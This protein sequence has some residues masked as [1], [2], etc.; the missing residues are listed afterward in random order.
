MSPDDGN[1]RR[2]LT[3]RGDEMVDWPFKIRRKLGELES[4][5][6]DSAAKVQALAAKR[7]QLDND[8]ETVTNE[9]NR[10]P[11]EQR[12]Q[13]QH[14][15]DGIMNELKD[16]DREVERRRARHFNDSQVAIHCREWLNLL[17][18]SAE[19]DEFPMSE[20]VAEIGDLN[21]LRFEIDQIKRQ[22]TEVSAA[23]L[24]AGDLREKV[25]AYVRWRGSRHAPDI[26]VVGNDF[27]VSWM[28]VDVLGNPE[29]VAGI[30]AWL[31]PNAFVDRLD[32]IISDEVNGG[33][34]VVTAKEREQRLAELRHKL[35]VNERVEENLVATLLS[36]GVD[37]QRRID[38]SPAAILMIE[39]KSAAAA[40]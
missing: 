15:I 9:M 21:N 6:A 10:L 34:K 13:Y 37:C 33:R 14:V 40:A 11:Q 39:V 20:T 4:I 12:G 17:S 24:P 18:P 1:Y 5:A 19:L 8:F 28:N 35:L 29:A 31:I 25:Q 3:A 27:R 7:R 30:L 2:P 36:H 22:I 26:K 32:E 23:P 16:W 38:A